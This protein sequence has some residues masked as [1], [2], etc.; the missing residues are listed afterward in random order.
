[1]AYAIIDPHFAIYRFIAE[2]ID[3][4]NTTYVLGI[5]DSLNPSAIKMQPMQ[6]MQ[7]FPEVRPGCSGPNATDPPPMS[8]LESLTADS[9]FA[10]AAAAAHGYL[11]NSESC[12][13]QQFGTIPRHGSW[14]PIMPGSD[15]QRSVDAA[16]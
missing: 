9:Y 1:M 4:V 8:I 16:R 14:L 12:Q 7:H 10:R 13:S 6:P 2:H 5:F 3:E 11:Q 15:W